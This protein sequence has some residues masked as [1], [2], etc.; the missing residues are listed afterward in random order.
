MNKNRFATSKD[1]NLLGKLVSFP[2]ISIIVMLIFLMQGITQV[3]RIA[4][5]EEA[6]S[7]EKAIRQSATHSY[8]TS[9]VYPESVAAIQNE[10]GVS[11]DRN[12]YLVSYEIFADNLM[13]K[14]KVI[15][16]K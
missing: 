2:V 16:L 15:R 11:Y 12:R 6:N 8:A 4:E 1:K 14:I 13:P 9:G 7:L 10:Y 3:D 5:N